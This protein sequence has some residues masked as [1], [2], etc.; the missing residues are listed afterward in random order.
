MY[1]AIDIGSN[2][3]LLLV[4]EWDGQRLI[5]REERQRIPRLGKDMDREGRLSKEAIQQ[6]VHILQDFQAFVDD[7]YSSNVP[8][9]VTAT[10]AV[11]E[12]AN[13]DVLQKQIHQHTGLDVR[14]ITGEQEARLTYAGALSTL[15]PK[16]ESDYLVVDVG[17]GSTEIIYGN[18]REIRQLQSFP[19]G[20]VRFTERYMHQS[21]FVASKVDECRSAI[22]R[23]LG[24][25]QFGVSSG[26]QL[27]GVE[28]T[29]TSL[30]Y[31][32]SGGNESCSSNLVNGV[33]ISADRMREV[34]RWLMRT[35][36]EALLEYYPEVMRGRADVFL[37]GVLILEAVM[38]H[39]S[40]N[41][42]TISAG[43]IRHGA[44]LDYSN[45][46]NQSRSK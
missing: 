34:V 3:I 32:T 27:I 30:A 37:A 40:M 26:T 44:I 29:A 10:S 7:Q 8:M 15:E 21:G 16:F 6:T 22:Y 36:P 20:S 4:A 13:R 28:G 12:A 43:G 18:A 42:L 25:Q 1:S 9:Y 33:L 23:L 14:I 24:S 2:T 45:S 17:G 41:E 38:H 19:M 11:R 31:I 46:K 35:D 39:F 5:T